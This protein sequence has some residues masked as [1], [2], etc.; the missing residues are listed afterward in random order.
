MAVNRRP[1]GL[2]TLADV[3]ARVPNYQ[4]PVDGTKKARADA[5]ILDYID[6][7][8]ERIYE[9]SGREFLS[10]LDPGGDDA[11]EAATWPQAPAETRIFDVR[12]GGNTPGGQTASALAI[13]D[14]ADITAVTL[15]YTWESASTVPFAL[16]I[17]TRIRLEP[18]PRAPGKP[19]RRLVVLGDVGDGDRYRVT[20]RWGFPKLPMSIRDAAA[21]QAAY[22]ANRDIAKYGETFLQAAAA[23]IVNAEPRSLIREVY[24]TAWLYH[25][26]SI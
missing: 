25:I 4:E 18:A 5:L 11:S 13:G 19:I 2:C 8:S 21:V 3:K 6:V 15:S 12:I 23:G 26:P 1:R 9:V 14:A 16:D 24:D 10:Y 20:G 22:Y 17:P 7:A